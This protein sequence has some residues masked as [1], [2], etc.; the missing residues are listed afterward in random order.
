[1][2]LKINKVEVEIDLLSSLN[3]IFSSF[4]YFL[5]FQAK[6]TNFC[7]IFQASIFERE[8]RYSRV[9]LKVF[10]LMSPT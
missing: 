6:T 3:F 9:K 4:L 7:I 1:M 8:G 10:D 2:V 5:L